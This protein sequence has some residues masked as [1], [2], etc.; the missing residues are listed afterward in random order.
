MGSAG[1]RVFTF[2]LG[3]ISGSAL[4]NFYKSYF[5]SDTF[6][7]DEE[8]STDS[9]PGTAKS[10]SHSQKHHRGWNYESYRPNHPWDFNWDLRS[11]MAKIETTNEDGEIVTKRQKANRHI[12]LI[13]HGQ[14]NLK[15]AN[16]SERIL[17]D[18]GVKQ[19]DQTGRR[20]AELGLPFTSIISS[21]MARAIQTSDIIRKHL[22]PELPVR[23]PDVLLREGAPYPPEPISR[24]HPEVYYHEDG[25]RIEAAFR[26]HFHRAEPSQV[27]L[28]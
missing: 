4:T 25:A 23:S 26:K 10:K 13:R 5:S 8:A 22:P 27:K 6:N 18:M 16:D 21:T 2:G 7:G 12:L 1:R 9:S 15:G 19:A 14:Y 11:H 20:L 24:W 28:V 3:A 17:T